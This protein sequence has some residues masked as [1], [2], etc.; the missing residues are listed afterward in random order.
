[1]TTTPDTQPDTAAYP[2]QFEGE[3]FYRGRTKVAGTAPAPAPLHREERVAH[4]LVGTVKE[5]KLGVHEKVPTVVYTLDVD[6]AH[7]VAMADVAGVL[8]K[9]QA[10]ERA[11]EEEATGQKPLLDELLDERADTA[12]SDDGLPDPDD[13][14]PE[15]RPA[16]TAKKDVWVDYAATL[17]GKTPAGLRQY[18]KAQLQEMTDPTFPPPGVPGPD[19]PPTDDG[20]PEGVSRIGDAL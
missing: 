2:V 9:A 10:A 13:T 4:L 17:L 12:D 7:Q 5:V 15:G 6:E 18:T 3:R 1:M 11:R 14:E 19:D 16:G 8:A 20:L